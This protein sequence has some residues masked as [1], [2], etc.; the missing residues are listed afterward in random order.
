MS[1]FEAE[2]GSVWTCLGVTVGQ[3]YTTLRGQREG[4]AGAPSNRKH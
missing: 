2:A 1:R 3:S 4:G